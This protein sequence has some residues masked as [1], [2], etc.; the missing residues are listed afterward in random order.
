MVVV[1]QAFELQWPTSWEE[2]EIFA[3]R[4]TDQSEC[5]IDAGIVKVV[6][7]LNLLGFCTSQSC[8][9]HLDEGL[10]YPWIDFTTG[11]CPAWY[12]QAQKDACCE[13]Q[14][15]EATMAAIGRLMDLV[16]AY[17]QEDHLYTRLVALLERFY[18]SRTDCPEKWRLIPH[19]I[20]PGYYRMCSGYGYAADE[21]PANARAENL[22]RAQ[23]EMQRFAEWLRECWQKMQNGMQ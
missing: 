9:G 4:L 12:E 6:A 14:S 1:E 20:H 22:A 10:P 7:A 17:H 18:A 11:A 21:W 15:A 19:C 5:P 2:A 8:E 23:G 16:A 13:G 3:G